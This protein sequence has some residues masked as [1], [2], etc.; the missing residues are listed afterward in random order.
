MKSKLDEIR[1]NHYWRSEREDKHRSRVISYLCAIFP[2]A[3]TWMENRCELP[4]SGLA[5]RDSRRAIFFDSRRNKRE[6]GGNLSPIKED[7][8][9]ELANRRMACQRSS[10]Q[11][12]RNPGSTLDERLVTVAFLDQLLKPDYVDVLAYRSNRVAI[13]WSPGARL[14][15]LRHGNRSRTEIPCRGKLLFCDV[16]PANELPTDLHPSKT[17]LAL[18]TLSFGRA[19]TSLA[20]REFH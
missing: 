10:W 11:P 20:A 17:T 14:P 4:T 8:N 15:I 13:V 5:S 16:H 1:S 12:K 18:K 7:T 9:G 6:I 2:A 3:L 19:E